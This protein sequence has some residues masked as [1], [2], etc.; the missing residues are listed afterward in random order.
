[1]VRTRRS[2]TVIVPRILRSWLGLSI[3][4]GGLY[5]GY[6]GMLS[7]FCTN[8]INILAGIN[9]IEAGQSLV[10]AVSLLIHNWIQVD[11]HGSGRMFREEG[12]HV[13]LVANCFE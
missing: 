9:G 12:L 1:M 8:A 6:M 7:V 13:G 4:V 10:I 2:T 5:F 3:N 11:R